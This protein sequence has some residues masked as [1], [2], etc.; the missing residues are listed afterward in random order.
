FFRVER[1]LCANAIVADEMSRESDAR[2]IS[3]CFFDERHHVR[4]ISIE[5][6]QNPKPFGV[7]TYVFDGDAGV[8]VSWSSDFA[9][10]GFALHPRRVALG[11]D[12]TEIRV[13]C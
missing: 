10:F 6:H 12:A 8:D 2:A 13:S 9:L 1:S 4:C 5:M 7:R 3:E 11:E